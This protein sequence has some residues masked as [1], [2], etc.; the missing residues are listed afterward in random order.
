MQCEIIVDVSF[1]ETRVAVLEDKELVEIYVERQDQQSIV[2]NI[3]KGVVENILPGMDAAFINIGQDKNAFLYLGDINRLEFGDTD[4]WYE[5]KTNPL[6]L[7]CGQEIVVQVIKEAHDQK[8]PRVTTNITLPGRYL[9]LLPNTDYTG[10]SKRIELEEERTRLKEIACRLKPE[11]M[12]I[13]VRTAAE[14]KSEEVLKNELEFLK[15]LWQRIKQKS[16]ESAPVLLYKDY[17][18]VFKAVRD[19]FTNQVDRFVINDRKKYNKIMEFL[20][21]YAPSL[22]SKVEYFNLATNIFEYFQIEQKLQKALSR[23]VWLKSGGYI[24]I[25]E[26]EALTAIDVN[27]GKFVG[28]NDVSETI[29]KT[30]LEA[31]VEIARQLR[32]RDIGGIIVIDFIDMKNTEHQ[33]LVLE[34]LKDALKKDK[35]KTVVVGITPLGLVEMTRKKVRQRLSCTLQTCCPYCEGTGKILSPETVA[36][37]ILKEIEWYF[38]NRVEERFF[39]ELNTKVCDVL[40]KGEVDRIKELQEKYK[41]KIYLKASSSIH[42]NKFTICP[43][44]DADHYMAL[45]GALSEG[46]EVLALVEEEDSFNCQNAIGYVNQNRIE[47][48][49]ASD[50]IGKYVYAKIEKV[51]GTQS[52]GKILEIFDET[53]E[54]AEEL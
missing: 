27:T 16:K 17:D 45:C 36:S 3:Y 13:I 21:A 54:T 12:G 51:Y 14:G 33:K 7:R 29:L 42:M 53:K 6:A 43:V 22:K 47:F 23:R 20:S 26:T 31:A 5:I 15:N 41:K 10:I 8:G 30:N 28:K 4:E 52:K 39:V 25:D 24:V 34:T 11:G 49:N 38:K 19:M 46:D 18:L 37:K 40:R 32:L 44:K 9:V 2:G 35:T 48:D 1:G 50:L